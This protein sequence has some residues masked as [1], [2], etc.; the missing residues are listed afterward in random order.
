MRLKQ[1]QEIELAKSIREIEGVISARVHLALPEKSVFVRDISTLALRG[2][3]QP[4]LSDSSAVI[5]NSDLQSMILSARASGEKP[6]K[7]TE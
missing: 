7:T 3:I 1:T 2:K 6:P 4:P 5:T